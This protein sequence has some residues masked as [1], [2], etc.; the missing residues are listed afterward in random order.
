MLRRNKIEYEKTARAGLAVAVFSL[1][2]RVDR[3]SLKVDRIL[4]E[5]D[6]IPV[7]VDRILM[8]VDRK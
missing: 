3:I 5:V 2:G 1:Q 4:K 6:R 8:E 7:K